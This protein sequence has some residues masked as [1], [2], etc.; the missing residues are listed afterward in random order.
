MK[1]NVK[2]IEIGIKIN[3]F[4]VLGE[5]EPVYYTVK[6]G[7][8]QM[9]RMVMCRCDCGNERII[10]WNNLKTNKTK[11]CGCIPNVGKIQGLSKH[12][13]YWVWVSMKDRC[14]NK[15]NIQYDN[16]GGRGVRVCTEWLNDFRIYYNWCMDN[17]WQKGLQIDK[18]IKGG[19]LYSPS[20]CCVVT[21]LE[22]NENK[23]NT[24]KV[25]INGVLMT[26]RQICEISKTS[27]GGILSRI[28]SGVIGEKL[29][30]TN[31]RNK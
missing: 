13:L 12:P 5:E 29:L 20:T 30:E 11:C 6:N 18:D 27:Y 3:S 23:R 10:S 17:G 25:N 24:I 7:H 4:T 15:N 14:Y 21:R 1:R 28:N 8:K 19:M 16:Y 2:E 31:K 22:N 9:T 26:I